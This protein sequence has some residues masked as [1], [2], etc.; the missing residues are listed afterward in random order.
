M[1]ADA[2][3]DGWT[4]I[5]RIGVESVSQTMRAQAESGDVSKYAAQP[6]VAPLSLVFRSHW[7]CAA[8]REFTDTNIYGE[9]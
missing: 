8:A 2:N 4:G 6:R 7:I 1:K 9:K 5:E 3:D